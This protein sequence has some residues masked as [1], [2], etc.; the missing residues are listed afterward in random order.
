[1]LANRLGCE[2][3]G[4]FAAIAL[5][6]GTIASRIAPSC[7]PSAPVAVVGIHG[8][9]D[10][11]V[12]FNGGSVGGTASAG[13]V[14]G[15]RATQELWRAVNRCSR[16]VTVTPLPVVVHDGTSV[17]RRAYG[18]C[19]ANVVWYEIKGGGHRWPPRRSEG[20]REPLAER[21]NGR[22]SQNLDASEVIWAFF[23]AHPRR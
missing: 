9:D 19:R 6:A 20:A 23:A 14:E 22:S 3:A 11:S 10:P 1:M 16:E 13:R 5:V 4:T 21:E 17:D 15:S 8:V 18:R 7:R 2:A 12:P